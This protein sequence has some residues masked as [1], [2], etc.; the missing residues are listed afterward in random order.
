ML[1]P[2]A[3]ESEVLCMLNKPVQALLLYL[4]LL[5]LPTVP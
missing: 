3:L 2:A 4:S 1:D 5:H